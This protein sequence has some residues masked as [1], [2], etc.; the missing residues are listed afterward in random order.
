MD[1][2]IYKAIAEAVAS[3]VSEH[4]ACMAHGEGVQAW[5]RWSGRVEQAGDVDMGLQELKRTGRPRKVEVTEE[6]A[7]YLARMY[8]RSNWRKDKGSM[9]MCAR[10]AARD[11]S[12]PLRQEVRDA[13]LS[14]PWR[15][16]LPVAVKEAMRLGDRATARYR[17]QKDGLTN[18]IYTPGWLRMA[19]DG[20]RR[21]LPGERQV[22]DDASVNIAVVVPWARGGDPCSNRYGVRLARFQLLLGIDCATDFCPG[23]G[24][25]MRANDAYDN[26]DV[27]ATMA[28]VWGLS[29]Y[30]PESCVM[31]GGSWQ[32]KNTLAFLDAA[33]VRLVSAKGRPNQKL[34]EG[35]FNRLWTALSIT[36]PKGQVGR[37]RGEMVKE[38]ANWT[39]CR[40][41]R[42][43]P[44]G[45]FPTV[46]E[47]MNGLQTAINHL[48]RERIESKVYGNWVPAEEYGRGMG[49]GLRGSDLTALTPHSLNPSFGGHVLPGGLRAFTLPVRKEVT[50]RRNGMAVVSAETP[51]GWDYQYA[52]AWADGWRWDGARAAVAFDPSDIGAGAEVTLAK[53][54]QETPAGTVIG[55]GVPCV[56]PAPMLWQTADGMWKAGAL[57]AR[58]AA[59]GV[60]R[61]GRALIGGQVATFDGRG[62]AARASVAPGKADGHAIGGAEPAAPKDFELYQPENGGG[63][64]AD[65]RTA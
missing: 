21:L 54:W 40:E 49:E 36:L 20:A 45:L 58:D 15:H 32:A 19:D 61:S 35:F 27:R 25:V 39:A 30:A 47:L 48:N 56:S 9:S 38:T 11:T 24:Y 53:R 18:G 12:S 43:D 7:D 5:R 17:N 23:F 1:T 55:S 64:D 8:M 60:K 28:R 10:M 44:R 59:R 46:E 13:I 62:T 16:A 65:F 42:R 6:E 51:Y 31:E 14:G 2:A 33:G 57:D 52:F 26:F 63:V 4:H 34:V 50:L 29:G 41:G 22:W 3:G 37:F